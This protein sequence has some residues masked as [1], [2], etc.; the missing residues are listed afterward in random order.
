MIFEY[1]QGVNSMFRRMRISGSGSATGGSSASVRNPAAVKRPSIDRPSPA[2]NGSSNQQQ[3]RNGN[4]KS[5]A[6]LDNVDIPTK[7]QFFRDA[8]NRK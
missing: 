5:T 6:A 1:L 8:H 4:D 2:A 3:P 7:S